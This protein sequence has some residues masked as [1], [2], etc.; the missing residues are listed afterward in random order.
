MQVWPEI[1]EHVEISTAVQYDTVDTSSGDT[2][3]SVRV[4]VRVVA[5]PLL[6]GLLYYSQEHD[7][8]LQ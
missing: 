3:A 5:S 4:C 6:V 8:L 1:Q 2:A 7:I